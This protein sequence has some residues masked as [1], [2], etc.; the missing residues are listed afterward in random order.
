[1]P[2]GWTGTVH[3]QKAV[4]YITINYSR[5]IIVADIANN[6]NLSRSRLYRVFM[7][8]I[9]ISPQQYLT[10]YRMRQA[11]HLLE[12]RKNS[13]KEIANAV[14]IEDPQYFSNLFKQ[15]TGKSPKN[16]MIDVIT[17]EK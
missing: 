10:E 11:I 14:G 9:F 16:Y 5:P 13:I 17:N 7:Q 15:V 8:Q 1:M 3:F 2:P 12:K 6:V 4:D